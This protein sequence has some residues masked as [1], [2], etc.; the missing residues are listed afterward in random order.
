LGLSSSR[1]D[2]AKMNN[3][4]LTERALHGIF[5][6][7]SYITFGTTDDPLPYPHKD[8]NLLHGFLFQK[9]TNIIFLW[10]CRLGKNVSCFELALHPD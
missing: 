9:P 10:V 6:T 7:T 2:L 3:N 4:L 1:E 5:N 8:G